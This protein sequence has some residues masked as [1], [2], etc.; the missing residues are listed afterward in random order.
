MLLTKSAPPM[1]AV[2]AKLVVPP[3]GPMRSS[4]SG[5]TVLPFAIFYFRVASSSDWCNGGM[6]HRATTISRRSAMP[7]ASLRIDRRGH[8]N[9]L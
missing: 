2:E 5:S 9:I 1:R 4:C 6:L 8:E 7:C 3:S